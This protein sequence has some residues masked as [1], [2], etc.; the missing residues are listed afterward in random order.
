MASTLAEIGDDK[1]GGV[2]ELCFSGQV[3]LLDE[4][5]LQL[6]IPGAHIA[7]ELGGIG[8]TGKAI[9]SLEER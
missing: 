1:R 6:R 4:S 5:G 7:T 3:E 2:I 9:L 8:G